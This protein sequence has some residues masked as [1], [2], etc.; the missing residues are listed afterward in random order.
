LT[1]SAFTPPCRF[2]RRW[3]VLSPMAGVGHI[4]WTALPSACPASTWRGGLTVCPGLYAFV[5]MVIPSAEG[6]RAH[7]GG[8][9][10]RGTGRVAATADKGHGRLGRRTLRV[11]AILTPGQK[12]PGLRQGFEVTRQRT[13]KGETTVE[14]VYGITSPGP[15][16]ADAARLPGLAREH[17]RVENC[18][19]RVRDV[20]LGEDA[21]R[22][23]KGSAPQVLAA[24][25]NKAAHLLSREVAQEGLAESRA[26]ASQ[27]LA[28]RPG[29]ALEVLGFPPLQ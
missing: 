20:T 4:C 8:R 3:Q 2:F 27:Y 13:E 26:A 21:C 22:A 23:R 17:W 14:V 5:F 1:S 25:R 24:L 19:H 18:L 11:T 29:E 7:R 10:A 28:A 15:E 9:Q 12:W 6:R 16:E